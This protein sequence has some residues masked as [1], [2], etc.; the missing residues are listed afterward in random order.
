MVVSLA[1]ALTLTVSP[2]W[3]YEDAYDNV[4]GGD[5]YMGVDNETAQ[6]AWGESYVLWSLMAM[7]RSTDHPMY[8]DRMARH[9]DALLQQRDDA[10]GVADYRGISGACWR[11]T[12]YQDKGEPYCYAVHSG[13]L[14]YPMADLAAFIAGWRHRDALAYDGAS[15]A[16][17]AEVYRA[18]AIAT[19]AYHD[20][21]WNDAGYYVFRASAKF[22]EHAGKDQPLNQ[23]NAMGLAL[24]ALHDLTGEAVYLERAT[25]L[26]KRMRGMMTASP[27]GGLVWNYWG[28]PY[29]APGEDISHAA[30]NVEFAVQAAARGVVF[31]EVDL[32]A[33]ATTFLEHVY[34]DDKTFADHVGGGAVNSDGYRA[35]IGRWLPLTARRGAVY[36]AIH[37]AYRR[38]YAAADVAS[39][40]M[41]L[42]WANLAAFEP[43]VCPHFFYPHDWQDGGDAMQA[44][45]YGANVLTVPPDLEVTCRVPLSVHNTRRTTAAQWDGE[46]MHRIVE[47]Q[48]APEFTARSVAYEPRWPLVY[49]EGGILFEFQDDFAPAGAIRVAQPEVHTLPTITSQPPTV[50]ELD[51]A[52]EYTPTGAGDPP[53]WWSLREGPVGL[54]VDPATGVVG[55]TPASPGDYLFALS[56]EN[57]LGE[58]VQEFTIHV[59][60][61][62][63]GSSGDAPTGG[64][65]PTP[66]T[67][68][69][70]ASTG[71]TEDTGA[72][73]NA[74]DTGGSSGGPGADGAG[75]A[76]CGCRGDD[77]PGL[78]GLAG[79]A[80]LLRRRRR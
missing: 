47:W 25:A 49:F 66:T 54:A 46:K 29:A 10:R 2:R 41:L 74:P 17:K 61:A 75:D 56:L 80:L 24:L 9:L 30:L 20:D 3:A 42:G 48:A 8:V 5:W 38:D 15:F 51:V 52:V 53:F 60:A 6:L 63:A 33:L 70:A 14:V 39:G 76:G 65:P 79:L 67:G 57:D 68:E 11:N 7:A 28:G 23:S 44:T 69:P 18:A 71:G 59:P 78:A 4:K 36:A 55:F 58:A 32:D 19:A 50:G 22:L 34:V 27:A 31:T 26:A 72:T 21:E 16:A 62:D 13:M 12:S 77:R 35:Q 43:R 40:S 73:G 1:L 37:D 64:D 45:A